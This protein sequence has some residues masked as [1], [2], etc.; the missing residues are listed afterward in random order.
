VVE[1]N[2]LPIGTGISVCFLFAIALM[3]LL[4]LRGP[5]LENAAFNGLPAFPVASTARDGVIPNRLNKAAPP[6]AAVLINV[7]RVETNALPSPNI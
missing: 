1:N 4:I 5:A 2:S 7:L 3:N 6:A